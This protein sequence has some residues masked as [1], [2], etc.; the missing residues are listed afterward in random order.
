MCDPLQA[1][2]RAGRAGR[3]APGHCYRLYTEESFQE[4]PEDTTPE[5]QRCPL[6]SVVLQLLALGI[7]DIL[8]FDFMDPPPEEAL[9]HAL[10][11]LYLLGGVERAG[12]LQLTALGRQMAHFPLEPHLAKAILTSQ[13]PWCCIEPETT[14]CFTYFPTQDYGC[15]EEVVTVVS[16][17]SVDSVL[18]T[19]PDQRDH[20]LTTRQ[21]FISTEGDHLTL[22]NIYR[23]YKAAKGNKVGSRR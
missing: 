22:L 23:G 7:S 17:L 10:E 1:R 8:G 14:S 19:P 13:V 6:T 12:Q 9:V 15:G 16:L 4:L 3:E 20:A 5:I 11:Q 18:F 21:K 2:Q